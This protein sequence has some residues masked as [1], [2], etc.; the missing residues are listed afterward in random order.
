M[1]RMIMKNWRMRGK[2]PAYHY[3]I[4]GTTATEA[5]DESSSVNE[6]LCTHTQPEILHTSKNSGRKMMMMSLK[7]D[8]NDSHKHRHTKKLSS[9]SSRKKR[10]ERGLK[11]KEHKTRRTR[12]RSSKIFPQRTS[13]RSVR[14]G[15]GL[16]VNSDC[17]YLLMLLYPTRQRECV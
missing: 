4:R 13:G 5:L 11:R 12:R 7:I 1:A 8:T 9:R 10:Q 6:C 2:V 3:T 15:F 16:V 14:P 17:V